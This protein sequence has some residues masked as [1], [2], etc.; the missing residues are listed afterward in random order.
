MINHSAVGFFRS[1]FT[2]VV[3]IVLDL[4]SCCPAKDVWRLVHRKGGPIP[5]H[6]TAA[7]VVNLEH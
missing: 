7:A 6:L 5:L 2:A 1:H 3:V 4:L